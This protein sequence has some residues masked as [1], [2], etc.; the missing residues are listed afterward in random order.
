MAL[1]AVLLDFNG[2]VLRDEPLRQQLVE[3]LLLSEN[4]RPNPAEYGSV[5]IGRSDRACLAGLLEQRGRIAVGSYLDKLLSHKQTQCLSRLTALEK[6]PIYPGL[7]DLIYKIRI[8]Q[9]KLAV[10]ADGA[11][12]EV[13][14][15][16]AQAQIDDHV[17]AIVTGDELP[18]EASKP[19]PES[20]RLAIK[21]L[22]QQF[23]E[24]GLMPHHCVAIE[25]S[26]AGI[27]AAKKA[28]VPVVGVAHT[29]PYQ[30]IH[31]RATWVVDYLSEIDTSWLQASYS[32]Q[33]QQ[34]QT[35]K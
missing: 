25:D 31:R 12:A 28:G 33:L 5:C 4:L 9:L 27:E 29:Y 13:Q 24:L 8:A 15:V 22:N 11:L 16:L 1:K 7:P 32:Q 21:K 19:A 2:V 23:P 35:A 10:I 6:L 34:N 14:W 20:Y 17:S 3:E 26:F 30:M 18:V